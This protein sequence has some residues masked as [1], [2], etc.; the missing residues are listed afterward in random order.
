[1][2]ATRNSRAALIGLGGWGCR[3]LAHLWPR[4]RL[5]DERRSLV[6][7][8]L[9]PI[10][11]VA[12][13]ALVMPD[14]AGQIT[15]ARPRVGHWDTPAFAEFPWHALSDKAV[16]GRR[17][18]E[19]WRKETYRRLQEA[20][21]V[22]QTC[23]PPPD[24]AYFGRKAI[25]HTLAAHESSITQQL[26]WIMDQARV[27]RDEPTSEI[28][29]LT[30]YFL[31]SLAEDVTSVL[32]WPLAALIRQAVGNYTPI[33]VIGLFQADSFAAPTARP[34][35][36]AGI[37]L[38]LQEMSALESSDPAR[39]ERIRAELPSSR[40]LESLGTHPMDLRYLFSREKVGGTMAQSEGELIAMVAN[41]LEAF[42]LSDADRFLSERLAP[43]LSVL[44]EKRSYSS[45]GAAS[46]YVPV[47]M[48]RARSRDQIRL[49]LL[50]DQF[51]APLTPEQAR[52]VEEL[53]HT[54]AGGFLSVVRLEQ[55][56]IGDT[57]IELDPEASQARASDVPAGPFQPIRLRPGELQPPLS[58][59]E[60]LGPLARV[61][62]IQH[63]FALL[64]GTHLPRWRQDL[65]IRA[66]MMP[67]SDVE[68]E[69]GGEPAEAS[70]EGSPRSLRPGQTAVNYLLERMDDF[71][72]QLIREGRRGSLRMAL[73]CVQKVAEL[74][75]QDGA[76]LS[77]Q[78]SQM[79]IPP[80]L[81]HRTGSEQVNR[82]LHAIERWSWLH[83]HPE[84]VFLG[85]LIFSL[86]VM[87][88]ITRA[89][90]TGPGELQAA[91]L[92][93]LVIEA[94]A[95]GAVAGVGAL[96][97]ARKQLDQ[98][99]H[100]LIQA[101]AAVIHRQL[102][103]LLYDLTVNAH[104]V[105]YE[106]VRERI[107]YLQR[108]LAELEAERGQL[109]TWL[110]RPL[111]ADA[112]YVRIPILDTAIYD[113][114]WARARRWISEEVS[115]RLWANSNSP[116]DE[117]ENAWR[118]T[119]QGV[120]TE[121]TLDELRHRPALSWTG[122]VTPRTPLAEAI[123]GAIARYAAMVSQ[124]YLPPGVSVEASLMRL[125]R[126]EVPGARSADVGWQLDDLCLR[127]RPF[128]GFEELEAELGTL[129]SIDLAAV[130]HTMS[131][132][133]GRETNAARRVHPI[134]SS[135]PFSIIVVR[136]LHG[137]LVESLPQLQSYAIT[138]AGLNAEERSRLIVSPALL[139]G[140]P[141][142]AANVAI[143]MEAY[144]SNS[145]ADL[146]MSNPEH[147]P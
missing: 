38:V 110:T 3:A 52:R 131:Q 63:H 98:L 91:G 67:A 71:L 122:Q 46:V 115:P 25:V 40:W 64:E 72:L 144:Q 15:V 112:S 78:R 9:T 141:S 41:A 142:E 124:P 70:P 62:A 10:H 111:T 83:H 143:A 81:R 133:V 84:W 23:T 86:I 24:I 2:G 68:E 139:G 48:M 107:T 6:A 95:I 31:A 135:D 1:M 74:V 137:L 97:L 138:F 94:I 127:A 54:L 39:H 19:A 109:A 33:E 61:E 73:H 87:T 106:K 36:L 65:L 51:L 118:E 113:G 49:H 8:N 101:K 89:I 130:P 21:E 42:L 75:Q 76:G 13:F 121:P 119:I 104:T 147:S 102:N 79:A 105:L 18:S 29:R 90:G 92:V 69:R 45:L 43:D 28:A 132:W 128:I 129:V 116:P 53:A 117:L 30:V 77:A 57:P 58:G 100:R 108:A 47:E 37:H 4:L 146:A 120:L 103:D 32:I 27:D 125:A 80:M 96:A 17:D 35:E 60:G 20:I 140:L 22:L 56:L 44:H 82:V 114:I 16:E 11:Y 5:A 123:S 88:A 34:Y 12:S 55:A 85:L 14:D 59:T 134:P 99:A 7:P 26:M 126:R 145:S 50:R 136:T 66:G 93:R